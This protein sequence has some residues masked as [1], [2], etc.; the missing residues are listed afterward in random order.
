M[1]GRHKKVGQRRSRTRTFAPPSVFVVAVVAAG[2]V[3]LRGPVGGPDDG[4]APV[5]ADA[6][7]VLTA[8][9]PA[10]AADSSLAATPTPSKPATVRPKPKP[11]ATKKPA[12]E[13]KKASR[14]ADRDGASRC[15]VD[16]ESTDH[17]NG[18]V[19]ASHLCALPQAK[20]KL[21]GDAADAFW[22]LNAAY[23]SEFG[24]DMCVSSSYRT[25]D[26]QVELNRAKPDLTAKPGTSNHG[27]GRAVDLCAGVDKFGT[28]QYEW[29]LANA[30]DY[31]FE[32]PSWARQSGSKPEAWHWEYTRG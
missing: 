2:V 1:P 16:D 27:W 28:P 3:I 25:F 23:R 4:G 5:A 10:P 21:H 26:E 32:N 17:P 6:G 20:H 30:G 24:E 7:T 13:T 8:P 19:P 11:A 14:G 31:G 15:P 12:R 9:R 29:M 18:K 22:R